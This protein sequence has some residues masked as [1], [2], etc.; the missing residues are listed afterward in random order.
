MTLD[1]VLS[2]GMT[3]W[4]ETLQH[5][6]FPPFV[7]SVTAKWEKVVWTAFGLNSS[8]FLCLFNGCHTFL[9]RSRGASIMARGVMSKAVPLVLCL[10][11]A[12][13]WLNSSGGTAPFRGV[14]Y[15]YLA[16][17][18]RM[19]G[20]SLSVY[21]QVKLVFCFQLSFIVLNTKPREKLMCRTWVVLPAYS[22]SGSVLS[23][24]QSSLDSK[25]VL[26]C[27]CCVNTYAAWQN[28]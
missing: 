16:L 2:P 19:W 22:S 27:S 24:Q 20:A 23:A 15:D 13:N 4:Y 26:L 5:S 1:P 11:L 9:A 3:L 14:L 12:A 25:T 8:G 6:G 18:L 17:Q 7:F 10:G 28:R 21:K